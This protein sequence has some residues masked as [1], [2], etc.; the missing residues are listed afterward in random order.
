MH[1]LWRL[2]LSFIVDIYLPLHW[3]VNLSYEFGQTLVY[4][5]VDFR[6]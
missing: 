5:V 4:K 1:L 6:D 3:A 2:A